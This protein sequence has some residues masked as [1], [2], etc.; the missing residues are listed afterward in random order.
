[1]GT[2]TFSISTTGQVNPN[3]RGRYVTGGAHT[4]STSASNLTDGAAGGGSAVSAVK[5]DI[6]TIQV[7]EAARVLFGGETAT[8]TAGLIVYASETADLEITANGAISI[9]DVA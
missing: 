4:T 3:V 6:L 8:A 9:I 2:A 1:M 5:G 7:D